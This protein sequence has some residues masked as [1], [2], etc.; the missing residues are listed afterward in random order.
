[1]LVAPGPGDEQRP[2]WMFCTAPGLPDG[3]GLATRDLMLGKR[4]IDRRRREAFRSRRISR[5]VSA[6]ART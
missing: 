3:D 5:M 6:A 4:A 2:E 1:M